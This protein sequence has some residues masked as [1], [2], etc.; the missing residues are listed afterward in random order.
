MNEMNTGKKLVRAVSL[1]SGGLDSQLSV[2]LLQDQGIEVHGIVF[3]S[4]F[5]SLDAARRA[6][7]QLRVPLHVQD[8]TRDILELLRSPPHGFGSCMNPC[9]DCHARMILRAGEYAVKEG[10]D[11]LCT[12]EV[13]NERPMSQNRRSLDIVANDSGH[14]DILLRP[15]SAKLLPET[16]MEREGLVDRSRL[17]ALQG[18]SRKIQL[19]M[20]ERYGFRYI[21]TPAGGCRL[22]EP[23]FCRRLDDLKKHEG[24]DDVRNINLLMVGRHFRLGPDVRL[25]V[26]RSLEDNEAIEK[27]AGVD[28]TILS[29]DGIP[30]PTCLLRGCAQ[31]AQVRQAASICARYSD[32]EAGRQV[33]VVVR[34][35][36]G[37]QRVLVTPADQSSSQLMVV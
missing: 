6:A 30:G 33:T 9:I 16:R 14:G 29:V 20:A 10:F 25:V 7:E 37:E 22:T 32:T 17:M 12:G 34:S 5:F 24:L 36:T 15:L 1:L 26:G 28:D 3:S 4:P 21:P 8:F 13:L 11:F 2:C 19:E 35:A 27:Q 18:R 23:N 31:E